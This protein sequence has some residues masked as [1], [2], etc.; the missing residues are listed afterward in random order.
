MQ[1]DSKIYVAG[2]LGMVGSA[3]IQNLNSKGFRNII[4][5]TS[6]ELNLINQHDVAVFFETEKPE[7]VFLA[8]AKVGGIVANNTFRADFIY[9]NI[10]IQ[11]N[12]IH[13]S[14]KNNV[15][16]LL[17]LGSSCIYPKLAPQP[18]KEDYLLTGLLEETNEPYAIAKIAGIKMC[19][20][21]RAQYGCSFIS[22]MPTNLYG[23]NDNYDL[24]NSHV[25]PAL[26]RKFHEAKQNNT[27][28]VIVWGSGNPL[29]EFL[30]ASDMADACVY[31]MQKYNGEGFVNIGSGEEIS[32]H[33][34]AYIIKEI[35]GYQ[36]KVSFDT[37]KPDGTPRKLTD[38][39]KLNALGW[40]YT[41]SL[42]QGIQQV[43]T[44]KFLN[45]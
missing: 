20:A 7:Y 12:V 28:E 27:A 39:T 21:Y 14:Y 44:E 37:S 23:F 29:R 5:R 42:K 16:K 3:I 15:K 33:E 31:L 17:F 10:L 1:F 30:H 18:L 13:E 2:H 41:I 36:G 22:V 32:I 11:S 19:D 9:Q 4:T 26:L 25:L 8:A 45:D 35:V 24:Q 43:Y 40:K 34:L 38:T 6:T